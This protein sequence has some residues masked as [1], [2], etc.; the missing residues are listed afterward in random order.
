[1]K[2]TTWLALAL[3]AACVP[4]FAG[5]WTGAGELG[6]A[7]ARGNSDSETL[8][9]KLALKKEDG[10]W[11][12]EAAADAL[13]VKGTVVVVDVDGDTHKV[14]NTTANRFGLGGKVGYKL[15]ERSYVFGSA[16]YDNDDF[17]PYEWQA[18]GSVG[19]GY[20]FIKDDR[21]ELR[22]E[23]GPGV[24]RLQPIDTLFLDPGPPAS[25]LRV[26]H[27][28]ETD[29][30]A[31]GAANFKH[32][33][34]DTTELLDTF[35]VESGGGRTFVQ[36]DLGLAV[37]INAHFSLKAAFQLRYN[38]ETPDSTVSTDRLFTTNLVYGF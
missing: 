25:V 20:W 30:V 13:R 14:G 38:S 15:T 35:L 2:T 6:L 12:Y 7:Y 5:E 16:R 10:D 29:L 4:A 9:A 17:A 28:G 3:G 34:T 18:V 21:T 22:G 24:R 1:M 27:D 37:K 19:Y 23:V 8:N 36:N 33:L 32:K 11:L 26:R 31:R